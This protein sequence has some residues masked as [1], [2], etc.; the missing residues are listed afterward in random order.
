[1]LLPAAHYIIG[2]IFVFTLMKNDH[3]IVVK[4]EVPLSPLYIGLKDFIN[5]IVT[6]TNLLKIDPVTLMVTW[7]LVVTK[8][9]Q[10]VELK[11]LGK[12]SV[13]IL[14]YLCFLSL[15]STTGEFL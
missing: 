2:M 1:M 6:Q 14:G 13:M 5:R 3:W 11:D 7:S 8:G 4:I 9:I 10:V 15:K 12:L